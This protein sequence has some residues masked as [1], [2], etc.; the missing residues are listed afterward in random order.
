MDKLNLHVTLPTLESV[1]YKNTLA[2]TTD[3]AIITGNTYKKEGSNGRE[4]HGDYYTSSFAHGY[5][6]R[7]CAP[8][9]KK[10][11][12]HAEFDHHVWGISSLGRM[13]CYNKMSLAT[14]IR[15]QMFVDR[16]T[17]QKLLPYSMKKDEETFEVQLG[18]YPQFS[19]DY[20]EKKKVINSMGAIKKTGREYHFYEPYH[21][22][23]IRTYPE[24]QL[25]DTRFIKVPNG[26]DTSELV[27][28]STSALT[29]YGSLEYL[30]VEPVT[31]TLEKNKYGDGILTSK[32][33]LLAGVPY[34]SDKLNENF[35]STDMAQFLSTYMEKEMFA[36]EA[37]K[38]KAYVKK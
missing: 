3:L 7:G 12:E 24:Y 11:Y 28:L 27:V 6:T 13:T 23:E 9:D 1:L 22:S 21:T 20:E 32:H 8:Y 31:W 15:L 35:Y 30:K 2:F 16:E 25:E 14:G 17:L 19:F 10:E 36:S 37:I 29:R 26:L 5:Y 18:A 38:E 4:R 33:V 34:D